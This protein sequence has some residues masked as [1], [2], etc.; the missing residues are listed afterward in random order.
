ME[1]AK[2]LDALFLPMPRASFGHAHM[3]AWSTT[4]DA[5]Y[6]RYWRFFTRDRSKCSCTISL[7]NYYDRATTCHA[8]AQASKERVHL[9]GI[10]RGHR[11]NKHTTTHDINGDQHCPGLVI[12]TG[13]PHAYIYTLVQ[14]HYYGRIGKVFYS[15]RPKTCYTPTRTRMLI[16]YVLLY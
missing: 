13:C 7:V 9:H 4:P 16:V 6:A 12:K 15:C 2:S 3:H 1:A 10:V 8:R 14:Q 11:N 5:I